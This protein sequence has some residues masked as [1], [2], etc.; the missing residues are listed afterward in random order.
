[1]TDHTPAEN[2]GFITATTVSAAVT[3]NN[4]VGQRVAIRVLGDDQKNYH[5][6]SAIPT[7]ASNKLLKDFLGELSKIWP[8]V[9]FKFRAKQLTIS[10]IQLT[11]P[12]VA[13]S[14]SAAAPAPS[15]FMNPPIL[16]PPVVPPSDKP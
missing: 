11:S 8:S 3:M 10:E 16:T 7:P 9:A 12:S 15:I 1:M 13:Q 4:Q 6:D 14:A 5:F 2:N